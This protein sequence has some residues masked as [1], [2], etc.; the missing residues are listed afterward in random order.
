ME[1]ETSQLGAGQRPA[2]DLAVKTR[3]DPGQ[4]VGHLREDSGNRG[5]GIAFGSG[6]LPGGAVTLRRSSSALLPEV[7]DPS[8]AWLSSLST[9]HIPR[10]VLNEH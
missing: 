4:N 6:R 1:I 2:V 7:P 10:S 9:D 3:A 8:G 5:T